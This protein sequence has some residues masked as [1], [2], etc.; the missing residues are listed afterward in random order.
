MK[1]RHRISRGLWARR[2][3]A[4]SRASF[5]RLGAGASEV[6]RAELA[7]AL[8]WPLALEVFLMHRFDELPY[9]EIAKR[10]RIDIRTVEICIFDA[11]LSIRTVRR[12]DFL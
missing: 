8:L 11:M 5:G 2:W 10:L 7:L 1:L 6:E 12:G 4:R 9:S 3:E